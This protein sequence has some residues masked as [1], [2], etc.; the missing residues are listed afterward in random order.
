MNTKT[1]PVWSGF[2]PEHSESILS[3]RTLKLSDF[4]SDYLHLQT[5]IRKLVL[6]SAGISFFPIYPQFAKKIPFPSQIIIK[7]QYIVQPYFTYFSLL[8]HLYSA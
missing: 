2:R 5:V 6:S 4:Y 3:I 7:S 8:G 1:K